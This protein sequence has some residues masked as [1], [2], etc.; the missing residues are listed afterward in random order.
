M[1]NDPAAPLPRA[2]LVVGLLWVVG[3][4][5]Y[6]DRTMLVTMHGSLVS[7]IPMSE[8]QFGLL[9]SVFLWIY[10]GLSPFAGYLADRA[11]RSR[12]IIA[13]MIVFSAV[14]ILTSYARSFDQLLCMRALMGVSEAC[15]LPAAVALIAD[16]HRGSTRS[17]AMAVHLTGVGVGAGLGGFGGLL[18]ERHTWHF[19]FALFGVLGIAY[20]TVL[21]FTLRDAP[22]PAVGAEGKLPVAGMGT[23][24]ASL[25]SRSA[26]ILVFSFYGVLGIGSYVGSGWFPTYF[27]EHFHLSQGRS[28]FYTIGLQRAAN[29]SGY[30][31]SGFVCDQV[32]RLHP[33]GRIVIPAVALF[34]SLPAGLLVAHTGVLGLALAGTLWGAFFGAFVDPNLMPIICMV[35]DAR[36]RATGYGILNLFACVIGGLAIYGAGALRDLHI[37]MNRILL[38]PVAAGAV[39]VVLLLLIRPKPESTFGPGLQPLPA[40]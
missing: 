9:T 29:F 15:Y 5:N 36:Y 24:L 11:G 34:I 31:I 3:A 10:G 13:S 33:R 28:G 20:G 25:F 2:W 14:T 8:G 27:H 22:A 37:G 19:P 35:T 38:F 17:F 16:Y 6:L 7:A 30:L 18:A 1:T 12:L 26:F 23:A 39:A 40:E 32:S 4:F 21:L